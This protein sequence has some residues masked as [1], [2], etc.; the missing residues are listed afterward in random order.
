MAL[1][2]VSWLFA[3][4]LLGVATGLRSMTPMALLCWFAYLGYLPVDDTWAAWTQKLSVTLAFT[5]LA[6]GELIADKMPWIPSRISPGPLF[7]RVVLAGLA[8][9][10]AA[11]AMQG[12]GVE[13]VLLAVLGAL[14]GAFGGFLVRRVLP[15]RLQSPDWVVA[16]GEDGSA[17]LFTIFALRIVSQ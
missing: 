15:E 8:G 11:T 14:L 10:I 3:V 2:I 13:G 4:P 5:V 12:P 17:V 7:G 6:V 1:A 9:S 16:L